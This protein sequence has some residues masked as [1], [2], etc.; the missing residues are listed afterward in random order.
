MDTYALQCRGRTRGKSWVWPVEIHTASHTHFVLRGLGKHS[1]CD[2]SWAAS[3]WTPTRDQW[4]LTR[5]AWTQSPRH[6]TTPESC[7]MSRVDPVESCCH[8]CTGEDMHVWRL[9]P[10][11]TVD[12]LHPYLWT[13]YVSLSFSV[14]LSITFPSLR[15]FVR[16]RAVLIF[17]L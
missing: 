13:T 12:S 17:P 5:T 7:S 16:V 4:S 8:V 3:T 6:L 14:C 1:T 15:L 11:N 9:A 10:R 2:C